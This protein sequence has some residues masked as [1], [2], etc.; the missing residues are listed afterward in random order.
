MAMKQTGVVVQAVVSPDLSAQLKQRAEV[1]DR[2]VSA[3]VR[4]AVQ[5]QLAKERGASEP[6]CVKC[7]PRDVRHLGSGAGP[8]KEVS[9]KWQ[10]SITGLDLFEVSIVPAPANDQTRVISMKGADLATTFGEILQGP[11]KAAAR[12][13]KDE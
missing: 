11:E 13:Q 3:V 10:R 8:L 9:E 4:R 12:E 6:A 7:A 2:S 1:E 5:N